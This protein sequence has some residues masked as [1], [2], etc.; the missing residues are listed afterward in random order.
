MFYVYEHI[1][2]DSNMPFYVGK[3]FGNR[4]MA[5]S[6]RNKHWHN[7]VNKHGFVPKI[8]HE[9]IDEENA[10]KKER[11][12][13]LYYESIGVKLCNLS[14]CGEKTA[15]GYR[16]T[17]ESKKIISNASIALW[18]NE[19]H[20]NKMS[21]RHS[22]LKNPFADQNKYEFYHKN[23]GK[24]TCTQYELG[25]RF[26]VNSSSVSRIA[27]GKLF[28][29]KGWILF[30]NY[31][32]NNPKYDNNIYCWYHKNYGIRFLR[33]VDLMKEF[34]I[35]LQSGLCKLLKGDQH[36]CNGW[37]VLNKKMFKN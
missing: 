5:K 25:S 31:G 30:K 24:I 33:K 6:G 34:P 19:R 36:T 17:N 37:V 18:K 27:S 9:F 21:I 32:V 14:I 15:L 11:E 8:I 10:L 13:Q 7:I 2:L 20:K 12:L 3:G 16:H 28:Q 29:Y 4:L 35:L 22:G 23:T 26:K 1:R